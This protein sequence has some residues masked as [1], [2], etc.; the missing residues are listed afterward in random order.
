MSKKSKVQFEVQDGET[1]DACLERIKKAGYFPI[2]R[3]EEPIFAER[4][5]DGNVYYVPINR[6]IV[7]EAKL[8]E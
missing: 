8:M 4:I 7:F 1:L 3:K 6:K 2:R 5:K